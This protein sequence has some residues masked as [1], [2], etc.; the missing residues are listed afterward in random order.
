MNEQYKAVNSGIYARLQRPRHNGG[1]LVRL[2]RAGASVFLCDYATEGAPYADFLS[3]IKAFAPDWLVMSTT[4]V[5]VFDG[6]EIVQKVK[7]DSGL[8]FKAIL[9]E[10]YSL[11]RPMAC[12]RNAT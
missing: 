3:G 12:H 1:N 2:D 5:T 4:N 8:K 9:K 11:M 7:A 10:Q 6:I